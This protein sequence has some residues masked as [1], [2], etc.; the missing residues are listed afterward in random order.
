MSKNMTP[1]FRHDGEIYTQCTFDFDALS[2]QP[3]EDHT[4]RINSSPFQKQK[5]CPKCKQW[6]PAT[7][8]YW[9]KSKMHKGGLNSRCKTCVH[10]YY[11]ANSHHLCIRCCAHTAIHDRLCEECYQQKQDNPDLKYCPNC[12]QWLPTDLFG[13]NRSTKDGLRRICQSC[14]HNVYCAHSDEICERQR[15]YYLT[16]SPEEKAKIRARENRR[17]NERSVKERQAGMCSKCLARP[18]ESGRVVCNRCYDY[19]KQYTDELRAQVF[20][21]YG[22]VCIQCGES[23]PAFLSIDHINSDGA[24]HRRAV[25]SGHRLYMWLRKKVFPQED[26]QLLC[27]NCN[28]RK[29]ISNQSKKSSRMKI[30]YAN[31]RQ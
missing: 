26:F 11:V 12:K 14:R 13:K 4:V 18:A 8:E 23:H 9:H 28:W 30:W 5:Y 24:E 16:R 21:S 3:I 15:E 10:N 7:T 19:Q 29:H 17:R 2:D 25:G 1:Q 31:L 6:L 27:A 20:A 22:G